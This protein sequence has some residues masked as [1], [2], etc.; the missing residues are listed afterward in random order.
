M[1]DTPEN[2]VP[3]PICSIYFFNKKLIVMYDIIILVEHGMVRSP[4]GTYMPCSDISLA[5][6]L[7]TLSTKYIF[8]SKIGWVVQDTSTNTIQVIRI[9]QIQECI[10]L[11]SLVHHRMGKYYIL[12]HNEICALLYQILPLHTLLRYPKTSLIGHLHI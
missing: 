7:V 5:T 8:F 10:S 9:V 11:P 3:P 4:S 6:C 12:Q 1:P 2:Y